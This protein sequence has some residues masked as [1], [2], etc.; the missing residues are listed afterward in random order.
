MYLKNLVEAK[1]LWKT[2]HLFLILEDSD[3]VFDEDSAYHI[4]FQF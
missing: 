4:D 3:A 1:T 2:Q